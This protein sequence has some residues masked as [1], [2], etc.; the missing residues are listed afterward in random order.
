VCFVCVV[1]VCVWC[2]CV[3]GVCVVCVY[4]YVWLGVYVC[5]V[6]VCVWCGVYV[7]VFMCVFVCVCLYYMACKADWH[8]ASVSLAYFFHIIKSKVL[9][10]KIIEHK[11]FTFIFSTTFVSK[12]NPVKYH[13][14][15]A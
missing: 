4:V 6:C 3:C 7:Y 1:C 8:I 14:K 13:H 11:M 5:V 2:V 15:C 12:Y 9:G 10:W